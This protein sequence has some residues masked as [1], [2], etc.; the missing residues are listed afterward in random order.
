MDL[1]PYKYYI[2]SALLLAGIGAVYYEI[3]DTFTEKDE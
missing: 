3:K 1:T 2:V